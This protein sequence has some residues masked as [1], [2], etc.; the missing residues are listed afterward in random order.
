[1]REG[2]TGAG[3]FIIDSIESIIEID[4]QKILNGYA[5]FSNTVRCGHNA[6]D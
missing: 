6:Y 3:T 1:M 5:I 2:T 4:N